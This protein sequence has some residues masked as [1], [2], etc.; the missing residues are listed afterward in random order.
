MGSKGAPQL[1]AALGMPSTDQDTPENGSIAALAEA[2][3]WL[4][5]GPVHPRRA[6]NLCEV[7]STTENEW[8][9]I[10]GEPFAWD[11]NAAFTSAVATTSAR[12]QLGGLF[13]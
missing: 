5:A 12:G 7:R 13:T 8:I 9:K 2:L 10:F 6:Q 11:V 4:E 1:L 3:Q